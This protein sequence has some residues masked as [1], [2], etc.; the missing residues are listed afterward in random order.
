M[1][2]LPGRGFLPTPAPLVLA[3][4]SD[5]RLDLLRQINIIPD[6][7]IPA[8]IDERPRRGEYP[9]QLALRLARAKAEAVAAL[10]SHAYV[11]G[12]DT[13][14]AR[15]RRVLPKANDET[16]AR[17]C[18]ELLSGCRHRVYSAVALIDPDGRTAVRLAVT[19]VAFKRLSRDEIDDYVARGEWRGKA[20][21]YAVQGHAAIFV[22]QIIGSYSGVVGLPLFETAALLTGCGYARPKG[23][24]GRG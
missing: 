12:A 1:Q 13:V 22:R 11:L 15:G 16:E 23:D 17:A 20:G 8:D 9:R 18:L 5:R 10:V 24:P 21:G 6:R 3:S 19:T 14:V 2:D 4:G 7:V